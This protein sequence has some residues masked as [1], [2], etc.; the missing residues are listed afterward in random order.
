[1]E[2]VIAIEYSHFHWLEW[3]QYGDYESQDLF[4]GADLASNA[5][6]LDAIGKGKSKG[7]GGYSKGGKRK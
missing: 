1:M 5:K 7:K 6:S 2:A 3:M 4:F